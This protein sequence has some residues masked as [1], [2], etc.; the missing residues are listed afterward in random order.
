[1]K[2]IYISLAI[3]AG[4]LLAAGCNDGFLDKAP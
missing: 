4:S 3:F 1:M 2:K